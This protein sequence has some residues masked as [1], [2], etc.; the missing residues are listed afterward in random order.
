MQ[1]PSTSTEHYNKLDHNYYYLFI[2]SL[3]LHLCYK[4]RGNIV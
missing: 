3:K 1:I 4:D 2:K